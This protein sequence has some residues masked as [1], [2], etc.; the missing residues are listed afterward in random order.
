MRQLADLNQ[1]IGKPQQNKAV[2]FAI[3]VGLT[4]S[5]G[6]IDSVTGPE[7]SLSAFY[8]IPST[9]AAWFLGRAFGAAA[10]A[11]ASLVWLMVELKFGRAYQH[12]LTPYCN[13]VLQ[14]AIA[15]FSAWLV[16]TARERQRAVLQEISG[17]KRAEAD[18]HIERILADAIETEQ[19]RIG[20]DLHDGLGQHLVSAGFVASMLRSKLLDKSMPEARDA[21]ELTTLIS[22]AIGQSRRLARGLLPMKLEAEGL[23]SALQELAD[24]ISAHSRVACHL[25]GEGSDGLFDPVVSSHL[26]RIAQEAINNALKHG[27]PEKIL[28]RLS[29][30]NQ[31]LDLSVSNDG[32]PYSKD[33]QSSGMGLRIMDHR[34]RLIGGRCQI[35]PGPGG[36]TV[37][38]CTVPFSDLRQVSA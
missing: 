22:D 3:S 4:L 14:L 13:G 31:A 15:L 7:I 32:T 37:V 30:S 35:G 20:R 6:V 26:Y 33:Q 19:Q 11:L 27:A 23:F 16:S 38:L 10:A 9:L 21:E 29:S 36:G 18:L 2:V 25:E 12:A 28:V 34:A 24:N 8:L 17:R 1:A 5:V